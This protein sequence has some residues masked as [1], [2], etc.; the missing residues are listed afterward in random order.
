VQIDS[1]DEQAG[2]ARKRLD[3]LQDEVSD[4][5]FRDASWL[6]TT[7]LDVGKELGLRAPR[8]A[9]LEEGV[10]T[11]W[12]HAGREVIVECM[13]GEKAQCLL[14]EDDTELQEGEYPLLHWGAIA[15]WL[16]RGGPAPRPQTKS[17]TPSP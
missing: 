10:A 17:E 16:M 11:E 8:I 15:R 3:A 2:R 4:G 6:M 9:S 14:V 5:A 7:F 13:G 1:P 12:T